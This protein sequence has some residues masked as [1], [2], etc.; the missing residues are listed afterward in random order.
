MR[1]FSFCQRFYFFG[2]SKPL[3]YHVR[4]VGR[5]VILSGGQRPQPNFFHRDTKR[6]SCRLIL[7][8]LEFRSPQDDTVEKAPKGGISALYRIRFREEQAPDLRVQ[9]VFFLSTHT[10]RGRRP[11]RPAHTIFQPKP[12]GSAAYHIRVSGGASPSPTYGAV[13]ALTLI[14]LRL[15][16]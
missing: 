14:Y 5:R 10:G 11:R 8:L 12:Y 2:R 4:G 13:L 16:K 1:R 3:P 9:F 6:T 15:V 7:A